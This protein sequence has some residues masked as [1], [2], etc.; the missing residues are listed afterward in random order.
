MGG[1]YSY[2]MLLE[3]RGN[4]FILATRVVLHVLGQK[5]GLAK[6]FYNLTF[7]PT[8]PSS[9]IGVIGERFVPRHEGVVTP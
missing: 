8:P 1:T 4:V 9:Y 6:A 2:G 7:Q 3:F 5:Q